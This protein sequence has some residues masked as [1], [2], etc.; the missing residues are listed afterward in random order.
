MAVVADGENGGSIQMS[1]TP[2]GNALRP[3]SY[4]GAN[5]AREIDNFIWRLKA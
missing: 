3:P 1:T 2:K 5:N 4:N